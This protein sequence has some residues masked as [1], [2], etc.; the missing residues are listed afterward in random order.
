MRAGNCQSKAMVSV[1]GTADAR[2]FVSELADG[3]IIFIMY[4]SPKGL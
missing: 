3:A 2:C 1:Y 4:Q